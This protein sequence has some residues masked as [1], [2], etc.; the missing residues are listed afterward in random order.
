MCSFHW[1]WL[2]SSVAINL[3][4]AI[5]V[6]AIGIMAEKMIS[7]YIAHLSKLSE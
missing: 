7:Q 5:V 6:L 1:N 2:T 3:I 4:L